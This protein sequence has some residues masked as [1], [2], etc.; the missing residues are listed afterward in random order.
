MVTAIRS[1]PGHHIRIAAG[2]D[3]DKLSDWGARHQVDRLTRN[4]QEVIDS[5]EV[6]IVYVA[7]PPSL[8]AEW[9]T[10]ALRAGKR[11]L[12]EKPLALD[13]ASCEAIIQAS[14]DYSLPLTH[15][16]GFVHHPRSHAMRAVVRSGELGSIQ[17]VTVACTF[18]TVAE[19]EQDHRFDA[20]AGGG[21]LLDLGWYCAYA[22]LWFTGL[23][24]TAIKSFGSRRGHGSEAVWNQVQTIAKLEGGAIASWDCGY[25]AAGR[26]WIEIAGSRGSLICDDFLRPWD[27]DKPRYWVHGQDGKARAELVG[28]GVLQESW[29]IENA[30]QAPLAA[31]LESLEMAKTTQKILDQ[32]HADT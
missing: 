14:R 7:L 2:R 16:T 11:V 17:R 15:A 5:P 1:R 25:D 9:T 23:Q 6:D 10:R 30:A 28:E 20:D 3:P 18:S 22:T 31:T 4:L 26:K 21:C 32:I 13:A 24:P 12:C 8:H 27:L 19:R 29:M